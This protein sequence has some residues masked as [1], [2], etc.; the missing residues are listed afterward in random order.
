MNDVIDRLAARA[1]METPPQVDVAQD[2]MMILR[3]ESARPAWAPSEPVLLWTALG[4][5]AA[6]GLLLAAYALGGVITDP[7][8]GLLLHVTEG[9][10]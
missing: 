10:L 1:R 3:E 2:V 4:S 6:A 7:L 5:A 9:M 8:T